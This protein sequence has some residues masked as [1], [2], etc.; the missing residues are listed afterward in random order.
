MPHRIGVIADTH[1]PTRVPYVPYDDIACA[2]D[3]VAQIVHLGDI[4]TPD[5]L[6]ALERI[7]PVVAVRGDDDSFRPPLRRVLTVNGVRIGLAHGQRSLYIERIRPALKQ[8][9]GQPVDPWNGMQADLLRWFAGDDVRA[10]L[11]GH[12]HRVYN[13][14]HDGVLLFN[15]GAVYAM[16][17]ASLRWQLTQRQGFLR[18]RFLRHHLARAERHPEAY[19][20]V[21]TVGVLTVEDDGALHAEVITLPPILIR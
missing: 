12:W 7:A 21:S 13:A 15:P 1:Y 9:L 6:A 5:V 14:S 3:G 11:F 8:W 10:I 2:F 18:E 19:Q 16:T 4:E 17:L 20:A